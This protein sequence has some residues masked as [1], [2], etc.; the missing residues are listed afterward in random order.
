VL[1]GNPCIGAQAKDLKAALPEIVKLD[2][3]KLQTMARLEVE[4]RLKKKL[5]NK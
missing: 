3:S 4:K 1:S 2:Q 5:K